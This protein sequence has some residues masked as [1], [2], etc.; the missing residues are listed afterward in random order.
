[1]TPGFMAGVLPCEAA[2]EVTSQALQLLGTYGY[3]ADF[4]V[5][6][7]LRDARGLMLAGQPVDNVAVTRLI[8]V[9]R[10]VA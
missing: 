6:R 8:V 1:M 5:E 7:Y 3:T 2:F 9:V 4:P 10:V